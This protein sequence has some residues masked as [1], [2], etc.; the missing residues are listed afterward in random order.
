[1]DQMLEGITGA[2]SVMDDILIAAATVQEHDV[3]LR[4]VFKKATSYNNFNK[5]GVSASG[6]KW[7]T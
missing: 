4:Q 2:V 5:C 6:C 1:M 3:I 7:D